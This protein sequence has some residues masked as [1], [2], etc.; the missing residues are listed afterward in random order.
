MR[1]IHVEVLSSYRLRLR[2]A[3]NAEGVVDLSHLVGK[4]VFAAWRKPGVFDQARLNS[5]SGTVCWTVEYQEHTT[6]IDL[7]PDVLYAKAT[8][9]ALPGADAA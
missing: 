6:E 3:D 5:E 1:V 2:F 7:D 9:K 4:G 8:G